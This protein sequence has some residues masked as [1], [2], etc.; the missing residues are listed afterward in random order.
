MEKKPH[1]GQGWAK[2]VEP[3]GDAIL[4]HM[5]D[6]DD[7]WASEASH[8]QYDLEYELEKAEYWADRFD[9][10]FEDSFEALDNMRL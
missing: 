1:V 3:C 5:T 7:D 2:D 6:E 8:D 9:A 10:M 4:Y